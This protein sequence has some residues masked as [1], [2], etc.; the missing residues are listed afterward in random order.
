MILET[1]VGLAQGHAEAGGWQGATT[2]WAH[3]HEKEQ[4]SQR[5]EAADQRACSVAGALSQVLMR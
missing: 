1:A 3:A 2:K 4:R 5:P